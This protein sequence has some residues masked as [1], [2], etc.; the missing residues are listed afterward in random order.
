MNFTKEERD[1][2][3]DHLKWLRIEANTIRNYEQRGEARGREEGKAEGKEEEKIAMPK[4]ML[5]DGEVIEKIIKY[6]KLTK[7]Q[8]ESLR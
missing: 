3:E 4:E 2:Y 8:L 1:A 6:T 5:L 7:E